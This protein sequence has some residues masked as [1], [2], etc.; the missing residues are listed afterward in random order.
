MPVHSKFARPAP[1]LLAFLAF[2]WGSAAAQVVVRGVPFSSFG[3]IDAADYDADGD[4]D[5]F[6]TGGVLSP[7]LMSGHATLLQSDGTGFVD[8]GANLS[9]VFSGD[10]SCGDLEGDGDLDLL[11]AGIEKLEIPDNRQIV[12]YEQ[13]DS[14]FVL[15]HRFRGVLFGP[16][17]WFDY[18]GDGRLDILTAGIQEGSLVMILFEL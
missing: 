6:V 10:V 17:I 7:D 14:G 16:T 12:V 9:G 5:L 1:L 15:R 13:I 11:V 8:S 2:S 4:D 3:A 18:N